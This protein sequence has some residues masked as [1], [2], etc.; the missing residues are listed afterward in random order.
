MQQFLTHE[1]IFHLG[2][3]F[4][5]FLPEK[6]AGVNCPEGPLQIWHLFQFYVYNCTCASSIDSHSTDNKIKAKL[7]LRTEATVGHVL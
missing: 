6:G 7:F 5:E 1:A 2:S 4:H 3:G